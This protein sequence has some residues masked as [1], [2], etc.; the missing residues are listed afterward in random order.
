[1]AKFFGTQSF[2]TSDPDKD[3]QVIYKFTSKKDQQI[4]MQADMSPYSPT[5]VDK[6][7]QRQSV[8]RAAAN[9]AV[10]KG[11]EEKEFKTKDDFTISGAYLHIKHMDDKYQHHFGVVAR[12]E[13]DQ[14]LKGFMERN[15]S[16]YGE[17]AQTLKTSDPRVVAANVNGAAM[18]YNPNEADNAFDTRVKMA[19]SV[20]PQLDPSKHHLVMIS[21]KGDEKKDVKPFSKPELYSFSTK[22]Y[23]DFFVS[24][25]NGAKNLPI[26]ADKLANFHPIAID[27]AIKGKMLEGTLNE[28]FQHKDQYLS[29]HNASEKRLPAASRQ[30][31]NQDEFIK[32]IQDGNRDFSSLDLRAINFKEVALRF[33]LDKLNN[34][35]FKGFDFSNASFSG[36]NLNSVNF[37]GITAKGADFSKCDIAGSK[38]D[39]ADISESSFRNASAKVAPASFKAAN[40]NNSDFK[41]AQIPASDLR[42]ANLVR[43]N[44]YKSNL[45]ESI[46]VGAKLNGAEFNQA[47]MENAHMDKSLSSY[48]GTAFVGTNLKGTGL[49]DKLGTVK[50]QQP[51][52]KAM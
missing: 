30:T 23:R 48:K 35:S 50:E 40:L 45:K 49:E 33:N 12:F 4:W 32:S 20:Y 7:Y 28:H 21:Q 8:T 13:N 5:P 17:N 24:R 10:E 37:S 22:S 52:A 46:T 18:L 51:A 31:I 11:A 26:R 6:T 43:A 1:M 29:M 3:K 15:A 27:H 25:I 16:Y 38:F 36:N 2:K 41:Y 42:D 19:L 44:F 47:N 34:S 14:Q 9:K 39:G